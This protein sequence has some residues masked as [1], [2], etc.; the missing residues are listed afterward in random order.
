MIA[1]NEEPLLEEVLDRIER[2]EAL[3]PTQL[4]ELRKDPVL[5]IKW[6][7]RDPVRPFVK[8]E[9]HPSRKVSTPRLIMAISIADQLLERFIFHEFS[10]TEKQNYPQYSNMVGFGRSFEHT[11]AIT[12]KVKDNS[13]RSGVGP[14]ASDVSG[15]ERRVSA[16]SLEEV[17]RVIHMR[18]EAA[19]GVRENF[20]HL[21]TIWAIVS[22]RPTYVVGFRLYNS[23]NF[24]MMPSGTFMTSFGNGIMRILFAFSA[25]AEFVVV[26]G[27][28]CLEWNRDPAAM[29]EYYNAC[30]LVTRDVETFPSSGTQF[31]FCSKYYDATRE[32]EPLVVPQSWAKILASYANLKVR[33]P[34]HYTALVS[35]LQGLPGALY[36][37]IM[38]W[39]ETC[40]F[41]LPPGVEKQ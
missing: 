35:E 41:S 10:K 21:A 12:Q 8:G 4:D 26:L 7:L 2:W 29:K 3:T 17:P 34:A 1:T 13:N 36:D 15:W 5:A 33:T 6:G 40:R 39:A 22:A 30:G 9:M 24:G 18:C 23:L 32:D 37:D 11:C 19:E 38:S 16:D 27:D 31:T 25:G 20:L 14:T 28:D